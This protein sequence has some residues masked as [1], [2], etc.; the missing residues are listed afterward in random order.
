MNLGALEEDTFSTCCHLLLQKSEQLRDGWSWESVQGSPEGYLK[1]TALRSAVIT[2]N[3]IWSQEGSKCN[4]EAH[5]CCQYSSDQQS[6]VVDEDDRGC[7]V[8]EGSSQFLQYEYHILYSCS[9]RTPVLYFRACTLEGRSLSLEEVWSSVHPDFQVRLRTSPLN[10]IS[11]Q[12]H[13]L[14]GQPF[15]MLHPCRT[16]EFM[17]PVL[18]VAQ[19]QHRSLNYVVVWL[20]VVGPLVGLDFPQEY[21]T[22]LQ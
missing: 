12:E 13:P 5:S 9:Y 20:S 2:S 3:A 7:T 17:R 19:D 4:S 10:T 22:L 8:P 15:F 16:Q 6:V 21:S 14:L 1:K 18:Q 11:Q